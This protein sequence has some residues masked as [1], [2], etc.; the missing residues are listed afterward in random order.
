[1]RGWFER[2][3]AELQVLV[4][5]ILQRCL[6][7][8]TIHSTKAALILLFCVSAF[9]TNAFNFVLFL[10][11]II[12]AMAN[13]NYMLLLWKT[14]LVILTLLLCCQY[15]VRIFAP[16]DY[17]L[18]IKHNKMTD[19]ICLVG[20]VNCQESQDNKAYMNMELVNFKLYLPYYALLLTFVL[21]YFILT[22][23]NYSSLL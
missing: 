20:I 13:N 4:K 3:F 12:L 10:M 9:Q 2:K 14:T 5:F 11:F 8:A 6:N 23:Q 16:N 18:S 1:M 15:S 22:S 19:P 21:S 17:L 7:F